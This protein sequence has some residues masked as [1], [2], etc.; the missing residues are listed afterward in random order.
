MLEPFEKDILYLE[1]LIEP[2]AALSEVCEH[3]AVSLVP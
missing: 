1:V 3:V 2:H